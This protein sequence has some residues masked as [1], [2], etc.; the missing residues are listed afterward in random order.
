MKKEIDI[1]D[2]TPSKRLYLSIIADYD[3]NRSICE[4]IDN[5][6]DVWVRSGKAR[7]ININ[8]IL[9]KQ[10][11]TIT[12][13]DN[14]GGLARSELRYI[15]GPGQTGTS[16]TDE[17][18]GIFGVGTKRAVVA[19]AQDIRIKTHCSN[20][21]TYQVDFDDK[22]LEDDDW[23]L[24]FYEVDSIPEGTTIVELQR[25]RLQITDDIIIQLKD[26]LRTTYAKF[27]KNNKVV[28]QVN[29][30]KLS[31]RFFENWAYPP[32][33][34]PQKYT[35]ILKTEDDRI[36][37]VEAV[38]GLSRE[39]SPAAGEYGVYFYCNDRL[40]ARALKTFDVGFTKGIAGLP[41]PKV[42]L[43]RVIVS[44]NGDARSMPWNSSKSDIN[45]KHEVFLALHNWLLQVVKDY[46][47]LSRIWMGDWPDKVFKHKVG[48]IKEIQI[49]DFPQVKKS[50]LPP[51][52]KSR[53]RYGEIITQKNRQV[54]KRKPW[55]KGIYEGVIAADFIIKQ[56]RLEQRNRIALIVLDS[57]LEI[58]FKEYL[59][60]D[61][62]A[63]YNDAK[64]LSI[65]SNRTSVHSEIKKYVK[66]GNITWKKIEHY[67]RLRCKLVHE[68]VTVG[69]DDDQ[70]QDFRDVVEQVLSKLYKL[71]F[72]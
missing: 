8:I 37:R 46:A 15:V 67:Y 53:P 11:Q 30:E 2:A 60:N 50:F 66:I 3:L 28:L 1:L 32:G 35:G 45:T 43:T 56:R 57:T 7:D 38:A 62:K 26:H 49:N 65:F 17:T 16:P 10:Q 52:P 33:Y 40:V 58:A 59:V 19:L 22:W 44:L 70:I 61:S 71:K 36:I 69:I 55:T 9:D 6:L 31:P 72:A 54:A 39:S 68:R 21:K 5:G 25:L 47:S 29:R 42:S 4:L 13:E 27:L 34:P 51:L 41:H 63:V 20:E 18:I 14:A 64:L 23:E 48:T 12:V 24:P